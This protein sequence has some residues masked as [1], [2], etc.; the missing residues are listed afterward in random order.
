MPRERE[1]ASV[2]GA[3]ARQIIALGRRA[4]EGDLLALEELQAI[5]QLAREVTTKAGAAAHASGY[6]YRQLADALG[7]SRQAAHERFGFTSSS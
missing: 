6:S 2:G 3:V 5:E 4:A 7:V 1:A